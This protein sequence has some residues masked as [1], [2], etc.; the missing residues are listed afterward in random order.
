VY[1]SDS[2]INN[3]RQMQ[4]NSSY[5][6][7]S[8][9]LRASHPTKKILIYFS[10][11]TCK[12]RMQGRIHCRK[13]SFS[14]TNSTTKHKHNKYGLQINSSTSR[15]QDEVLIRKALQWLSASKLWQNTGWYSYLSWWS[16]IASFE[17]RVI[18]RYKRKGI[19][20]ITCRHLSQAS[21]IISRWFHLTQFNT[22]TE[23]SVILQTRNIDWYCWSDWNN[24][25]THGSKDKHTRKKRLFR[26]GQTGFTGYFELL[27]HCRLSWFVLKRSLSATGNLSLEG[28]EI[29]SYVTDLL[30]SA[31]WLGLPPSNGHCARISPQPQYDNRFLKPHVSR[32]PIR[33]KRSKKLQLIKICLRQ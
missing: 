22:N 17:L 16:P 30:S 2:E 6:Q 7:I 10:I 24:Q 5:T 12:I 13:A 20:S 9:T 21:A 11:V 18:H 27:G 31:Q 32:K 14:Q 26:D 19:R 29:C 28:V 8:N 1:A 3:H 25:Y 33:R 4:I 15:S 23:D